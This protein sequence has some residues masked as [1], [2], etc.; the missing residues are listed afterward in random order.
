MKRVL[1]G[2]IKCRSRRRV[3]FRLRPIQTASLLCLGRHPNAT[4]DQDIKVQVWK[5]RITL[6]SSG[7]PVEHMICA[8]ATALDD[9]TMFRVEIVEGQC[10]H[11]RD[12][13][14]RYLCV[15]PD[16]FIVIL[17]NVL[18]ANPLEAQWLLK[19]V[20]DTA[21]KHMIGAN[22]FENA[23]FPGMYFSVGLN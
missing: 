21:P 16:S 22:L 10:A 7:H 13:D 11:L 9:A 18:P 1:S 23:Q 19:Q 20:A 6:C 8:N 3:R 5:K 2:D 12:C 15:V 17:S 4:N 14:G